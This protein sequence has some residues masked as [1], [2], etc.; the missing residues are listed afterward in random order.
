MSDVESLVASVGSL[1]V[2]IELVQKSLKH[3]I[4]AAQLMNE[5]ITALSKGMLELNERI[6][7]LEGGPLGDT[8]TFERN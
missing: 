3:T 1:L 7:I 2:T 8:P 4:I 5:N 6:E